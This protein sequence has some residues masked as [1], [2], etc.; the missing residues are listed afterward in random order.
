MAIIRTPEVVLARL[1]LG[2]V[3][4]RDRDPM[5]RRFRCRFDTVVVEDHVMRTLID[6]G[7]VVGTSS[8]DGERAVFALRA[9]AVAA[10]PEPPAATRRAHPST[11]REAAAGVALGPGHRYVLQLFNTYGAMTAV[12]LETLHH[13]LNSPLAPAMSPSRLR[14][15]LPELERMG[16]LWRHGQRPTGHTTS[17]G[18]KT[19]ATLWA[20]TPP[21][22]EGRAAEAAG[23]DTSP[24]EG[25]GHRHDAAPAGAVEPSL[26]P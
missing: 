14:S 25:R 20:S 15:S 23:E 24:T 21:S 2:H 1:K 26:F 11:S 10:S 5:S 9:G 7:Q 17:T 8:G 18:V 4:I 16:K 19:Y 22:E 13:E 6:R 12:E 3:L